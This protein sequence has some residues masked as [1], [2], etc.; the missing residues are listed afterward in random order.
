VDIYHVGDG[1]DV[2]QHEKIGNGWV[3]ILELSG[4]VYY[5]HRAE[6]RSQ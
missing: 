5:Y 2:Q 6:R 4:E 3:K 1:D